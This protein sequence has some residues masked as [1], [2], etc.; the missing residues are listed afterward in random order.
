VG[1]RLLHKYGT[2]IW[3]VISTQIIYSYCIC[4]R[5]AGGERKGAGNPALLDDF[6]L[7]EPSVIE[8]E[9]ALHKILIMFVTMNVPVAPENIEETATRLKFLSIITD[10][11]SLLCT[12]HKEEFAELRKCWCQA[13]WAGGWRL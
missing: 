3:V 6:L 10:T 13:G 7:V 4:T 1:G 12:S 2:I 11:E 5:V 8:G 9:E